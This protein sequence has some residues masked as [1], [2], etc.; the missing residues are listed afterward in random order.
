MSVLL[1]GA[2]GLL[3]AAASDGEDSVPPTFEELLKIWDK[4][5]LKIQHYDEL[6]D[7]GY[8]ILFKGYHAE[9]IAIDSLGS[10]EDTVADPISLEMA[11]VRINSVRLCWK[12]K[13]QIK[14]DGA[15]ITGRTFHHHN[16]EDL[17]Y[18]FTLSRRDG[19]LFTQE[20]LDF[21]S[22]RLRMI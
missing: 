20:E 4:P 9:V 11:I 3:F 6:Y 17:Y 12:D 2:G 7:Q 10:F 16:H 1:I 18:F 22:S 14:D 15:T 19:E 21:I 8:D 5:V 13:I